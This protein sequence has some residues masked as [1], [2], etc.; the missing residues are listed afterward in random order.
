MKSVTIKVYRNNGDFLKIWSN[1]KFVSFEKKINGGLGPC[2]IELG[3]EFNYDGDDLKLNNEIQI[4]ITDEDTVGQD[5]E[6]KRIYSGYISSYIPWVD[7]AKEGIIVNLLGYYTKLSQ[8]VYITGTTTTKSYTAATDFGAMFRDF[9]DQ[10][11]T[12]NSGTRLKYTANDIELTS[13]TGKAEFEMLTYREAINKIVS[14]SPSNW[15][16]YVGA[17]NVVEFHSKPSTVT[18][19]FIMGKH[20][21]S[22]RVERSMERMKNSML[23][24]EARNGGN[25]NLREDTLSVATYG[26]RTS[27]RVVQAVGDEST[28]NKIA[29][30]YYA[31]NKDPSLR[32]IIDIFDNNES[33]DFGYDIE[34]IEPGHTCSLKGFDDRFSDIFEENMLITEVLYSL[35][36]VTIVI[37]PFIKTGVATRQEEIMEFVDELR[38]AEAPEGT[39]SETSFKAI[40]HTSRARVSLSG[41]QTIPNNA[42]TKVEFDTE[43]YDGMDEFDAVT[44]YRFVATDAGYYQVNAVVRWADP[45][46]AKGYNIAIYKEGNLHTLRNEQ[47]QYTNII[48][49]TL[50]DIVQLAAGERIE[51][52]VL[53]D[54]GGNDDITGGQTF[55]TTMSIHKL[56]L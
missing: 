34:S 7:G 2:Q 22:I 42:W 5:V 33:T 47:L 31:E 23:I 6:A 26:R 38:R 52:F 40:N 32:V 13:D 35:N 8:D 16:W 51:L 37:E 24:W 11:I 49:Q 53:Q 27:K 12:N 10:Y 4:F 28:Q 43:Q 21:K 30:G 20:F 39:G 1:A 9:I 17:L 3:E 44:N 48:T 54:S 50:S 14:M 19:N 18:H 55:Y 15:W 56:S 36:K 29:D 46:A 25:M 45:T 41:N